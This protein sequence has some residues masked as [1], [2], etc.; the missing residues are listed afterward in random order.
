MWGK[1]VFSALALLVFWEWLPALGAE[2]D[3]QIRA[4]HTAERGQLD[5]SDSGHEQ[6]L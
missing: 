1:V 3:R 6:L 5:A 4:D 2:R